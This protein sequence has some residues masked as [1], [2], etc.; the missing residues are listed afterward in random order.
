VDGRRAF[1]QTP[2]K[3][4]E[5]VRAELIARGREDLIDE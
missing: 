4:K 1:H 2:A 3:L 5:A